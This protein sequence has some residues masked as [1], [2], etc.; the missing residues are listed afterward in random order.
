M[1]DVKEKLDEIYRIANNVLYFDDNSDYQTVLWEVLMTINPDL[2]TFEKLK[3][4]EQK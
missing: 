2:D 1:L 4:I 3:Y